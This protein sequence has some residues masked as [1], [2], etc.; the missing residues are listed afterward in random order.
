[1][2]QACPSKAALPTQMLSCPLCEREREAETGPGAS[3]RL[4]GDSQNLGLSHQKPVWALRAHTE[5]ERPD[6]HLGQVRELWPRLVR[7]S[8]GQ[9]F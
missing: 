4:Q 9:T 2:G 6:A 3:S 5:A 7:A 8:P 1:M